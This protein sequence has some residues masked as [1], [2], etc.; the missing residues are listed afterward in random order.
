METGKIFH[1]SHDD[2]Y[3]FPFGAVVSGTEVC[4]RLKIAKDLEPQHVCLVLCDKHGRECL[5][6]MN[7][8][9]ESID[10]AIYEKNIKTPLTPM[11]L[12]Y[13]FQI[14]T[15]KELYYYGNNCQRLGG[16]GK[17]YQNIPP[18]YQIT[19]YENNNRVPS[20]FKEGIVYQIFVDRFFNGCEDDKVLAPKPRALIHADWHDTPIY[21][22]DS[23]SG[24]ILR[25]DFFGGNLLGVI[26]K[27]PYLKELGITCIYFN[28]IFESF[29]NHKYDTG[30]YK[31]ID[32]MYGNEET[33][34]TLCQQAEALGISIILDGVF[35]HTGSDSVYFNK[36]GSY[37]ALGAYQSSES[38]YYS[39]YRFN[40]YPNE[41]ESWWGIDT[42]PNV[43]EM[44]PSYLNFIIN[45]KDSVV[46]HWMNKGVK[47]WRLDVADEL[48]DDFIKE[49]RKKVNALN[50]ESVLIGE[51]WED[52]SNK[53]SYGQSREYLLGEELDSVTNYPLRQTFLDYLLGAVDAYEAQ[54]R[55]WSLYENY[56]KELFFSTLNVI[57]THD[58]P[59]ILTVL[60][61]A[62]NGK[63]LSEEERSNFRLSPAKRELAKDRLKILSLLQMTFPGVPCIYYG[64]EVGLEGY[65]DPYNRGPY[66]WGKED[67]ALLLWYQRLIQLRKN[68]T[69]FNQGEW[70]PLFI[71]RDIYGFMLKEEDTTALI[72]VN[73]HIQEN[74][75]IALDLSDEKMDV[76]YDVLNA[77]H[78]F[79]LAD[80]KLNLTL[81][82]LEGK[83]LM[84]S[85]KKKTTVFE[86]GSGIL[87]HPTSLPSPYGVGD[88]GKE[89]YHFVDFLEKAGQTYWQLLPLTPVDD[90]G[91]PYCS[92]S[93]FA[94]NPLLISPDQLVA[95]G[96]LNRNDVAC[97]PTL[98]Q[99][100]VLYEVVGKEK[101][102]LLQK[103]FNQFLRKKETAAY[104]SFI[105]EHCFWLDDYAL[106]MALKK[107]L[108]G[109][110]NQWEPGLAFRD[111]DRLQYY[112]KKLQD[113]INFQRFVQFIFYK[114]WQSLKSYAQAKN[115]RIIG[116]LPIYVAHDSSDVWANPHLF[117]LDKEGTPLKVAGV[118]PDYFCP[119]GQLWGNPIYC[120]ERMEKD[121]Y[122]WWRKRIEHLLKYIDV[123]RIDHFRGFES[124]WEVPF[125]EKT[126]ERGQWKKGPGEK[127]FFNLEESLPNLPFIAEDLGFIT[128]EVENLRKQFSFPGMKVLQFLDA[129]A[130]CSQEMTEKTIYYTGTH[131]NDTLY[132]W[133]KKKV[134]KQ[135]QNPEAY[136]QSE[137]ICWQFIEAVL[138]SKASISIIPLQDVLALDSKAR[139]NTPG[140]QKGNW[141]WRFSR[142]DLQEKH[143]QQL[144]LLTKRYNRNER[145]DTH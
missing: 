39:W 125:G 32:P 15:S 117:C 115:I 141:Q 105:Q 70:R 27:L 35:N 65:R 26:K 111:P 122:H 69:I 1:D 10:E 132:G 49:L 80:G 120:W 84:S 83:I 4:L 100:N 94:G 76:F 13:Y 113:E 108:G 126:A 130:L 110:W 55:I 42:L 87:L 56:P 51:V 121:H 20:W 50:S 66:P 11:L 45:S 48:P 96:L 74:I 140:T 73:R 89:S 8:G 47:G 5:E 95:E 104:E 38:P 77:S 78:A 75:P 99:K 62:P 136:D 41:Y 36:E 138:Q 90:W 133:Y 57:G 23:K 46:S 30:N 28:P 79:H 60:G 123:I 72:F 91:S 127:L 81:R 2:F 7:I 143:S 37:D 88:L 131:D 135:L 128:S 25:W 129:E 40:H 43:N 116:D 114:Q 44:D 19:V 112:A 85:S 17:C 54:E 97:Y 52:A 86:R 101:E 63:D 3:R 58:V 14:E 21:I 107:H 53:V 18:K 139:M 31:K 67:K 6:E 98:N 106:F 33:F 61:E 102:K 68:H 9:N 134:L 16:K 118:P 82:H 124:Y 92:P 22:K 137:Q 144:A 29:S 71:A 93:A 109:S 24:R 59:R 64:D 34:Q 145:G 142:D 103:A 119:T 12:W